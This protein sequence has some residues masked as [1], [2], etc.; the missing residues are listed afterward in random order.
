MSCRV[1]RLSLEDFLREEVIWASQKLTLSHTALGQF[2][3]SL[4]M[5]PAEQDQRSRLVHE[6]HHDACITGLRKA[7]ARFEDLVLDDIVPEDLRC[8]RRASSLS[9]CLAVDLECLGLEERTKEIEVACESVTCG[10]KALDEAV[11]Q[12]NVAA[13]PSLWEEIFTFQDRLKFSKAEYWRHWSEH[14]C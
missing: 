13:L 5:C 8:C 7:L 2:L 1:T 3:E 10:F 6:A 12:D 11:I 9:R 4:P 14:S